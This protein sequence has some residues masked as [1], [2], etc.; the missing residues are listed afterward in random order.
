MYGLGIAP[1]AV[2]LGPVITPKTALPDL[3]GNRVPMP[4][5]LSAE[6]N[7]STTEKLDLVPA[8]LFGLIRG[9]CDPLRKAFLNHLPEALRIVEVEAL[10]GPAG[11]VLF[12]R[13]PLGSF[14]IAWENAHTDPLQFR[15]SLLPE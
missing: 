14:P 5:N 6:R 13:H 9:S 3:P 10:R 12:E 1:R 15:N 7:R 2:V 11:Q 8:E 4:V